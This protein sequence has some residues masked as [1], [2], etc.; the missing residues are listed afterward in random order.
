MGM[1][2]KY[3]SGWKEIADALGV[4]PRTVRRWHLEKCRIPLLKFGNSQQAKVA[5]D[6]QNLF[7]WFEK[8]SNSNTGPQ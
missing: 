2:K 8:I 3:L 4:H 7:Q 5:I 6:V 1:E